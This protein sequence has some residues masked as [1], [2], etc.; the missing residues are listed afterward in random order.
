MY[1]LYT[2][3]IKQI[4]PYQCHT[5]IVHMIKQHTPALTMVNMVGSSFWLGPIR[6]G[7][8]P[9]ASTYHIRYETLLSDVGFNILQCLNIKKHKI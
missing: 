3:N 6:N 4:I 5:F 1:N 9:L 8:R 2:N 7:A